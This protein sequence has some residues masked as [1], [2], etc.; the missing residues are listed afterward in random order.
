MKTSVRTGER[1]FGVEITPDG[2][3]V[4]AE[5]AQCSPVHVAEFPSGKT[6][7]RALCQHIQ[8]ER[9]HSHVCIKACGAAALGVLTALAPT[10]GV[11]V[12]LVPEQALRG[13]TVAGGP[14][15]TAAQLARLAERLF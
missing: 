5:R 9:Q 8:R 3:L 1:W 14:Q 15:E 7:A 10:P 4:V 2:R 12:T 6:G 11:E 13:A